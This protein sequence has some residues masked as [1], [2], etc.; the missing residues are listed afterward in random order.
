MLEIKIL[1]DLYVDTVV[2]DEIVEKLVKSGI[3]TK[4]CIDEESIDEVE[5]YYN[6]KGR[7]YKSRCVLT[8]VNGNRLIV[9][10]SYEEMKK[11]KEGKRMT[12]KG[13]KNG[14]KHCRRG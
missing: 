7:I 10:H 8:L 5:E 14:R 3:V 2:G 13:F 1:S 9:K 4:K 12:V 6:S 11:I